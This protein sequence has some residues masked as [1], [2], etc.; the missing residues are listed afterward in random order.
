MLR[1]DS[2]LGWGP[3]TLSESLLKEAGLICTSADRIQPR[4]REEEKT[5]FR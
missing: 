5:T 2:T 3:P 4:D 1:S